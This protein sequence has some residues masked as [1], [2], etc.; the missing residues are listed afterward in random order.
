MNISPDEED[1]RQLRYQFAQFSYDMFIHA[2]SRHSAD[3]EILQRP[4]DE[5]PEAS[6]FAWEQSS[7]ALKDLIRSK[8]NVFDK[9]SKNN[10]DIGYVIYNG[11]NNI[12]KLH[13]GMVTYKKFSPAVK[14]EYRELARR[15]RAKLEDAEFEDN[16]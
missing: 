12:K 16:G 14:E 1:E 8:S 11:V 9:I 15:I 10:E 3:T 5:L 4:F 13:T 7:W 6:R 2:L